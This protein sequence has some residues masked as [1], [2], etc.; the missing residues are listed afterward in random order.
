MKCIL[1]DVPTWMNLENML[2]ERSQSQKTPYN[3]ISFTRNIQNRH[4]TEKSVLARLGYKCVHAWR[5]R[6][7]VTKGY[8][9]SFWSDKNV[10]KL[11]GDDWTALRIS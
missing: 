2:N 6:K 9:V 11:T 5:G 8:G 1:I 7:I 4:S 10:L 3:M